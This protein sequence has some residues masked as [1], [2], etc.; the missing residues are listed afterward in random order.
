SRNIEELEVEK[1]PKRYRLRK[2]PQELEKLKKMGV[3]MGRYEG[4]MPEMKPNSVVIDDISQYETEKLIEK[5]KP[6]VFCAGIKEKYTVQKR[7]VPMKQLHSYDYGGP[8]AAF[9]GAINF[10]R[11]MER[12]VNTKIWKLIKAPWKNE[13][14]ITAT[15]VVE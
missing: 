10:Y 13:P 8:F 6:A 11:D 5:Y 1:D 7:G 14:E 3:Q 4:M 12:T 9:K 2:S 15:F